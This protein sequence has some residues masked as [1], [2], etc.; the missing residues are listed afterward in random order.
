MKK[1]F[2]ATLITFL[3]LEFISR[4]LIFLLTLNISV[5][6]YGIDKKVSFNVIDLSSFK[7]S[8][9]SEKKSYKSLKKISVKIYQ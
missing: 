3:S 5:F 9:I 2:F 1:I 8:I 4:V 7:F 6:T